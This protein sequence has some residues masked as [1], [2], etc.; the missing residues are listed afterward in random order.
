MKDLFRA[1]NYFRPDAGRIA[2]V[3]CLLVGSIV[4]NVLKPWPLA[5]MVDCV[6]GQRRLPALLGPAGAWPK[7]VQ[8]GCLAA[9]IFLLHFAPGRPG[10]GAELLLDSG[11]PARVDAGA[12]GSLRPIATAFAAL[13]SGCQ[14]RRPDLSRFLG[15]LFFPN[16]VSARADDVRHRASVVAGDGVRHVAAE[17][18]ADAGGAGAGAAHG[19]GH[20]PLWRRDARTHDR[21]RNKPTAA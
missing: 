17:R 15:H 14:R 9:A 7:P 20:P 4:L 10:C 8:L 3:F 2:S 13:S 11:R 12:P 16:F 5:L 1:L 21:W 18:A 19:H 6:L